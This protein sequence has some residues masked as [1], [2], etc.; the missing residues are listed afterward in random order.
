MIVRIEDLR[1]ALGGKQILSGAGLE[2]APGEMFGLIGPNGSG[3]STLLRTLYRALRPDG[4]VIEIDGTDT[5]SLR[6]RDQARLLSASTQDSDHTA[7]L[8]VGEVVESGRTA[9]LGLVGGLR[10]EDTAAVQRALTATDLLHLVGQ[11]VRTLSGGERQ[12]VSLAR[13]LATEPR[14][15]V[16]DEPTNHLDLRHQL[17]ILGLLRAKVADGLAVLITLHDLRL[18]AEYC[19][20]LA[21]LDRGGIQAVGT[22]AEVL[23]TEL[24]AGV[25]GVAGEFAGGRLHIHGLAHRP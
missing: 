8:S 4:G 21:V 19:D 24:L 12:R 10:A 1:V 9:H 14:I 18:A 5:R 3:K 2:A 15:L 17:E 20:R 25:F 6:R 11:D 13:A 22:P 7:A 16:L 23:S